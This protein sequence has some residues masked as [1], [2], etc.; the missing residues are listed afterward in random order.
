MNKSTRELREGL[1]GR[2][3]ENI[4]LETLREMRLI[5]NTNRRPR[6]GLT[7]ETWQKEFAI[8]RLY[9]TPTKEMKLRKPYYSEERMA[10]DEADFGKVYDG[11]P[12]WQSYCSFINDII[13]ELRSGHH[14]Y[15]YFIYQILE[16]ERFFPGVLQTK[17]S[18]GYW[19][20]WVD[21]SSR[22]I[23]LSA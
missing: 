6:A 7:D 9:V 22:R 20:V 14:D 15:C 18:D 8:Q 12:N 2:T 4:T 1:T 13:K 17:Y 16:L 23:G 5:S 3:K 19:E 21:Y 10:T 11:P